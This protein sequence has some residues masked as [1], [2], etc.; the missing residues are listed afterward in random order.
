V[1]TRGSFEWGGAFTTTYWADPKERLIALIYTNVL[2]STINLGE[3]FKVLV[4][5]ALR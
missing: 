5:S 3:Q 2:G 4:Y 1:L